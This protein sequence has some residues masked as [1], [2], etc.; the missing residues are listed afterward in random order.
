M[1]VRCFSIGTNWN[2]QFRGKPAPSDCGDHFQIATDAVAGARARLAAC[3]DRYQQVKGPINEIY[4]PEKRDGEESVRDI[5]FVD[6]LDAVVTRNHYGSLVL[7]AHR[8]LFI[9]VDMP[10]PDYPSRFGGASG[11][12]IPPCWQTTFDDLR[13]VLE[14]ERHIGFRI[15]RTAAGFRILA[16]S[17]EFEPGSDMAAA[18]MTSVAADDAFVRLCSTQ[19]TFRARLTPKPWR[20][21]ATKPPNQ[22]PRQSPDQQRCFEEWL[23]QYE[24]A[25][26][27]RATCQFLGQ[28]GTA[29]TH[30]RVAPIIQFHDRQTRAFEALELA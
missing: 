25:C 28:V 26:R 12:G 2:A 4:Y 7:N 15:Y 9:D 14:S 13:M 23:T 1:T 27:H 17:N 29:E 21:G 20:C 3:H 5:P 22:F 18:L 8:T 30:K 16:T 6:G 11:N 24:R 19:K 10:G